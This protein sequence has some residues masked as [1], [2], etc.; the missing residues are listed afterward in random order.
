[1]ILAPI[2]IQKIKHG[3]TH[4]TASNLPGGLHIKKLLSWAWLGMAS[5]PYNYKP[6]HLL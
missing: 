5:K 3:S 2:P 1:V 4:K 6:I